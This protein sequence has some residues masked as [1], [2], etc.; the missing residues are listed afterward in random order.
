M[1]SEPVLHPD[2]AD[3]IASFIESGANFIIVGAFAMAYHELPRTTGDIDFFVGHDR[4]NAARVIRALE[5][6]G[7]GHIKA[8]IEDFCRPNHFAVIGRAPV[9]VDVLTSITG[10]TF[11]EAWRDRQSGTL[12]GYEVSF[13]SK[14]HLL[15]NKLAT[16][17]LKDKADAQRLLRKSRRPTT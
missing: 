15:K 11:E 1:S 12:G 17:R 5:L 3:A 6:F 14:E 7:S 16:G 8:D 4:E 2:W 9:R 10:V 13:P